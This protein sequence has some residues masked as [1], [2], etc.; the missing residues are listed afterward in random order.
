MSC[1]T[2]WTRLIFIGLSNRHITAHLALLF[3]PTQIMPSPNSTRVF[4]LHSFIRFMSSKKSDSVP[5]KIQASLADL[6]TVPWLPQVTDTLVE[7]AGET[8]FSHAGISAPDYGTARVLA[9]RPDATCHI[10]AR[11]PIYPN[12]ENTPAMLIEV[13]SQEDRRRYQDMGLVFR[14]SDET[15]HPAVFNCLQDAVNFLRYVPTLQTTIAALVRVCHILKA[16][17]DYDVSQSDPHVPFSIFISVPRRR[18]PNDALRVI[19]SIVHEAMHLQLT[20]IERELPL[21]GMSVSTHFS[22]WKG[23]YRSLQGVLHALYVFRVIDEFFKRLQAL[24][25]LSA[26]DASYISGRREEISQ[27]IGEI[28]TFGE[29]PDLT[30]W[31]SDVVRRLLHSENPGP[32]N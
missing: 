12:V 13:L 2:A 26:F 7:N 23:T 1:S 11:L 29:C 4:A 22:P 20:L 30:G 18:R 24:S 6:E 21:V 25:I 16:D 17:D 31:G 10:T 32:L 15:K 19:E 28:R 5:S 27:Q 3:H 14:T 8:L 9:G